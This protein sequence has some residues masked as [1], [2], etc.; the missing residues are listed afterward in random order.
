MII[1][2]DR[3]VKLEFGG[4]LLFGV[5]SV[6]EAHTSDAAVGVD[7]Q[8]RIRSFNPGR[9]FGFY[10]NSMKIASEL[11]CYFPEHGESQRSWFRT[12]CA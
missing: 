7:L 5:Q 2:L 1:Y 8:T 6:R 4:Q 3:E 12:L 10:D 11:L 9:F